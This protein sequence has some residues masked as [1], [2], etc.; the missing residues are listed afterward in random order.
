M[1]LPHGTSLPLACSVIA[2]CSH[3]AESAAGLHLR[4]AVWPR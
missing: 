3:S 1:A 4:D 2:T